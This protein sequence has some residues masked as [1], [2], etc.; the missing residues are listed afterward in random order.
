MA[1]S[2]VFTDKVYKLKG[3]RAPL[4]FSIPTRNSVRTPLLHFDEKKGANRAL[5]YSKNQKSPFVDEQD[6]EIILEP[7]VFEN[8]FLNVPKENQAL[9]A[10]LPLH[11]FWN[12]RFEEVNTS[13]DAES[14]L[15]ALDMQAEAM[16][17][18]RRM[19][20]DEIAMFA[21]V[22]FNRDISK[23]S[24]NELRRDVIVFAKKSSKEF[25]EAMQDPDKLFKAKLQMFFDQK[26][27]TFRK[28]KKEVWFSTPTN[29]TKMMDIPYGQEPMVA[30]KSYMKSD[31]GIDQ[32]IFLEDLLEEE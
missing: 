3:V 9:Q 14:E 16:Y 29:K 4:S 20:I 27:L 24:S 11:P 15:A 13:R 8:G 10:F 12:N 18:A 28:D 30:V 7:V 32:M 2:K 19:G 26:L 23:V 25:L 21:R 17:I 22:L 31:N 1:E 5:R 6:G